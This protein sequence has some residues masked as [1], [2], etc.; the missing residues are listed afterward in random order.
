MMFVHGECFCWHKSCSA[1]PQRAPYRVMRIRILQR[2]VTTSIDGVRLDGFEP[3]VKYE[4]GTSIGALLLAEGWAEPA[5]NQ[6][7]D[8]A[9]PA[10][11]FLRGVKF[12]LR[13][14]AP[15]PPN[16]LRD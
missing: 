16:L 3:G 9:N 14:A 5:P 13:T 12:A 7:T 8:V 11:H 15:D 1:P 2:P 10:N 4:V 6:A